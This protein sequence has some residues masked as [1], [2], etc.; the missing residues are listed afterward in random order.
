MFTNETCTREAENVYLAPYSTM[1]TYLATSDPTRDAYSTGECR[2]LIGG[3][4]VVG[5]RTQIT[6]DDSSKFPDQSAFGAK[7]FETTIK[8][9]GTVGC[10]I[11]SVRSTSEN[12]LQGEHFGDTTRFPQRYARQ[13]IGTF[14]VKNLTKALPLNYRLVDQ[15]CVSNVEDADAH[16]ES[17]Q[18]GEATFMVIADDDNGILLAGESKV[19]RFCF[20]ATAPSSVRAH[21]LHTHQSCP[22][23]IMAHTLVPFIFSVRLG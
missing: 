5:F 19:L 15:I 20:A 17:L 7:L 9:V 3:I 22:P 13:M 21:R 16:C 8:F 6:A 18:Y 23:M 10:S 14:E 12:L 2:E 11:L 1:F 4:R